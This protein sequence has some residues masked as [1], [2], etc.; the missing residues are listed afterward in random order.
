MEAYNRP[1]YEFIGS[2]MYLACAGRPD[3]MYLPR[4]LSCYNDTHWIEAKRVLYY[5]LVGIRKWHLIMKGSF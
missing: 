4:F 3:I 2:F 5:L 1:H